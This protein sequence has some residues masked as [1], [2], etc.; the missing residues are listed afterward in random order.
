MAE[1]FDL[2]G[3][4]RVTGLAET[5]RG[6]GQ[7]GGA[8]E[9][10]AASL[11]QAER[12][13]GGLSAAQ[14]AAT[15]TAAGLA[16]AQ[17][18]ATA[19]ATAF[20]TTQASSSTA[21]GLLAQR[22]A[23]ASTDFKAGEINAGE[24]AA[25]VRGAAGQAAALSRAQGVGRT[26]GEA[27]SAIMAA[28]TTSAG[29]L[30][31]ALGLISTDVKQA[32]VAFKTGVIT[33]QEY[34]LSLASA[35]NEAGALAR[36][37]GQLAGGDLR[38][39][40]TILNETEV[41]AGHA[42]RGMGT[43]R[44]TAAT[45]VSQMA[46]VKT[47][48]G[49][50]V[51]ALGNMAL[52]GAVTVGVLGGI[53]AIGFAYDKLTEKT[54]KAKEEQQK[55]ADE[56]LKSANAFFAA[57]HPM[58]ALQKQVK[59]LGDAEVAARKAL[60]EA[61]AGT[62]VRGQFG[63]VQTVVDPNKVKAA[64]DALD[65]LSSQAQ[66]AYRQYNEAVARIGQNTFDNL[67]RIVAAGGAAIDIQDRLR[68]AI[69]LAK[70]QRD[71]MTKAERDSVEGR[72]RLYDLTERITSGEAAFKREQGDG[73]KADRDAVAAA[74]ARLD[75][76]VEEIKALGVSTARLDALA[77]AIRLSDAVQKRAN[78]TDAEQLTLLKA[79]NEAL[80]TLA[81]LTSVR[82]TAGAFRPEVPKLAAPSIGGLDANAFG[83]PSLTE[84]FG[85]FGA[86]AAK[87]F[88]DSLSKGFQ[89]AG[90]RATTAIQE[91][92]IGPIAA[93]AQLLA[94][95]GKTLGDQLR[96]GL[97]TGIAA[98]A[99]ALA[100]G[101]GNVLL[102]AL[103]GI[104][105]Q[106]GSAMIGAGVAL[107][108][109]LPALSNPFT[110]GPALIAAGAIITGLGAALA[111]SA[112]GGGAHASAG[113]RAGGGPSTAPIVYNYT[114]GSSGAAASGA[115]HLSAIQPM[116]VNQTI[117]GPNDPAAQRAIALMVTKAGQRGAA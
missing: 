82:G 49:Q 64:Q 96:Q 10:T 109:L 38:L 46:G 17:T 81:K 45:L 26:D 114:I 11:A 85:R 52:G 70:Q 37:A 25:A 51:G 39:L 48:V 47:S 43:L 20:Q 94:D 15:A 111:A 42:H 107:L 1:V 60:A 2:S 69:A 65:S 78:L 55:L 97:S 86:D 30:S 100:T 54:R 93:K 83:L 88:S 36:G 19:A 102:G 72:Q 7:V 77:E 99:T 113:G 104:F 9:S 92:V 40:N 98:A 71:A 33:A 67:V 27:F 106:M 79:R 35:R 91:S 22:V 63:E 59:T 5:L 61:Q 53:A 23:Q 44:S 29:A 14:S 68:A 80:D 28:Q 112:T 110:S 31:K 117:I 101:H 115:S 56:L 108:H 4:L 50:V 18:G 62:Q 3:S 84:R 74:K 41:A 13:A 76:R 89:A 21:L 16:E 105:E 103:G 34:A 66:E 57:S 116:T 75:L 8:A 12:A 95:L 90:T 73:T 6:L 24:Y 87:A 32:Q 58:D